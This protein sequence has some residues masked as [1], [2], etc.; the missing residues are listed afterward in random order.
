[1]TFASLHL[2]ISSCR[3]D[4][5]LFLGVSSRRSRTCHD[6][7]ALSNA[8]CLYDPCEYHLV[9]SSIESD[10]TQTGGGLIFVFAGR[11][12]SQNVKFMILS[13]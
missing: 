6:F 9:S 10:P 4:A 8:S 11:R 5:Y 13:F 12:T 3:G 1:M 2:G 7:G